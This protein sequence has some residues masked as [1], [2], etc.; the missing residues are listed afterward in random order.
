VGGF[1]RPLRPAKNAGFEGSHDWS[2][3]HSSWR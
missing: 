2:Q 3:N 1:C